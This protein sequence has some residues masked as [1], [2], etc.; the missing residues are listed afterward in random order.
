MRHNTIIK[1]LSA[2]ILVA[3][4]SCDKK[5][6]IDYEITT[7]EYKYDLTTEAGRKMQEITDKTGIYFVVD[8]LKAKDY[9]SSFFSAV[10]YAYDYKSFDKE[11]TNAALDFLENYFLNKHTT[12]FLKEFFPY[13]FVFADTSANI[14]TPG[15][16]SPVLVSEGGIIIPRM[17]KT[18]LYGNENI[19]RVYAKEIY[20]NLIKMYINKFKFKTPEFF[21]IT[22]YKIAYPTSSANLPDPREFGVFKYRTSSGNYLPATETNDIQEWVETMVKSTEEEFL[23]KISYE[24]KDDSGS[25]KL[26]PYP[27]M[28][29]KYKILKEYVSKNNEMNIHECNYLYK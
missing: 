17:N 18:I 10:A 13:R 9:M 28:L 6:D 23:K 12:S 4:Y 16:T 2:L 1:L 15:N 3:I 27:K 29:E 14:Y 20:D 11:N 24:E 21:E 26:T 8:S 22:D 25:S 5:D 19:K 7:P